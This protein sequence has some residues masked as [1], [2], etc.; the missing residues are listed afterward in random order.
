[1]VLVKGSYIVALITCSSKEEAEKIAKRLLEAKVAA[2][3]NV[4]ADV[5]S[6]F[7]WEGRI[8]EADEALLII[9]T[10]LDLFEELVKEVKALHSYTVPEIIAL[11]IIEGYTGYLN[12]LDESVK[13]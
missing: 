13:P 9:K 12:W 2:C 6:R 1:M 4:V 7:W 3:I 10:R 11:P 8:D 5:K